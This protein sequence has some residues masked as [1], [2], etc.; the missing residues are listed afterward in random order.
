MGIWDKIQDAAG[1]VKDAAGDAV[2]FLTGGD[3]APEQQVVGVRPEFQGNAFKA[4][5]PSFKMRENEFEKPLWMQ[6]ADPQSP[7]SSWDNDFLGRV[8]KQ[9]DEL[10][11]KGELGTQFDRNDATGVVTW[12]HV[13]KGGKDLKF[14][15][16]LDKGKLIGNLYE[17]KDG[18]EADADLMMSQFLLEPEELAQIGEDRDPTSRMRDVINQRRENN[19]IEIPQALNAAEQQGL[20]DKTQAKIQGAFGGAGDDALAAGIGGIGGAIITGGVATAASGIGFLP[21][22]AITGIG[23]GVSGLAAWLNRDDISEQTASALEISRKAYED[24]EGNILGDTA[25]ASKQWAG[26]AGK[27]LSP[28]S[29]LLRGAVD[30]DRGNGV[31]ALQ[32]EDRPAWA[33]PLDIAATIADMGFTFGSKAGITAY[34]AQMGV[35]SAGGLT[36]LTLGGGQRW[37]AQAGEFRNVYQNEKGDFSAAN[38]LGAWAS[39]G[40]D[41][42][43]LAMV[44]GIAQKISGAD[45][46]AIGKEMNGGIVAKVEDR[47]GRRF[48]LDENKKVL[49]SK[50]NW[51][52]VMVPSEGVSFLAAGGAARSAAA[53]GMRPGQAV[54][55]DFYKASVALERAEAPIKA[56]LV[57]AVGE[58]TEEAVQEA[59]D[60]WSFDNQVDLQS[61]AEA[62]AYGAASGLGMGFAANYRTRD[63]DAK[64]LKGLVEEGYL[65][66]H[67]ALPDN[68]DDTYKKMSVQQRN[69]YTSAVM[70]PEQ[71]EAFKQMMGDQIVLNGSSTKSGQGITNLQNQLIQE[72]QDRLTDKAGAPGDQVNRAAGKP[73]STTKQ[74]QPN[75]SV[76]IR[77]GVVSDDALTSGPRGLLHYYIQRKK[78]LPLVLKTI[79]TQL[80]EAKDEQARVAE[81]LDT[82]MADARVD[83]L[84][85][86]LE[87]WK[88]TDT[89]LPDLIKAVENKV[90]VLTNPEINLKE[91]IRE[92]DEL[93]QQLDTYYRAE[94]PALALAASMLR[95]RSPYDNVGSFHVGAPAVS[96]AAVKDNVEMNFETDWASL[97]V[98]TAD[99]DGDRFTSATGV[100]LSADSFM[101]A[102]SGASWLSTERNVDAD[103]NQ[104]DGSS[105]LYKVAAVAPDKS[106]NLTAHYISTGMYLPGVQGLPAKWLKVFTDAVITRYATQYTTSASDALFD[107]LEA[108]L[109]TKLPKDPIKELMSF[110]ATDPVMSPLMVEYAKN[111]RTNEPSV[112]T[113]MFRSYMDSLQVQIN[114]HQASLVPEAER[115][116]A[117]AAAAKGN[118]RWN[119]PD[120]HR[121]IAPQQGAT[122]LNTFF[123]YYGTKDM[124][125]I[126]QV[127]RLSWVGYKERGMAKADTNPLLDIAAREMRVLAQGH[128]QDA[129]NAQLN[130][131]D[132]PARVRAMALDITDGNE[133]MAFNLLSEPFGDTQFEGKD[134]VK[135]RPN[136]TV[137]QALTMSYIQQLRID[138][139]MPISR[140]PELQMKLNMLETAANDARGFD[141]VKRSNGEMLILKDALGAF[142][143]AD[144]MG[145]G[146]TAEWATSGLLITGSIE[147]N[148]RR[149]MRLPRVDVASIKRKMENQRVDPSTQETYDSITKFIL[150]VA[151]SESARNEDRNETA[152]KAA[153]EVRKNVRDAVKAAGLPQT[154]EGVQALLDGQDGQQIL[155]ALV[156]QTKLASFTDSTEGGQSLRDWVLQ[157]FVEESDGKAEVLLWSNRAIDSITLINARKLM[158]Q[159]DKDQFGQKKEDEQEEDDYTRQDDTLAALMQHLNEHSPVGLRE[160]QEAI[161]KASDRK[162]LEE[163]ISQQDYSFNVP[164]LMYENSMAQFDPSLVSGGWGQPA[165]SYGTAMRELLQPSKSFGKRVT[166]QQKFRRINVSTAERLLKHRDSQPDHPEVLALI[167]ELESR[168]TGAIKT[169]HPNDML[170]SMIRAQY[171]AADMHN[172]GKEHEAVV[173][174]GGP[175]VAEA[176]QTNFS[177]PFIDTANQLFDARD[178]QDLQSRP[179]LVFF[180]KNFTNDLGNPVIMPN[181]RDANGDI[182]IWLVLEQIANN[183]ETGLADLLVEAL[184]PKQR[185]FNRLTG[186]S[187]VTTI[188]PR[189]LH[190]LV[191]QRYDASFKSNGPGR[192]TDKALASFGSAVS[193]AIQA[194]DFTNSAA[195]ERAWQAIAMPRIMS[196]RGWSRGRNASELEKVRKQFAL[197]LMQAG[198]LYNKDPEGYEAAVDTVARNMVLGMNIAQNERAWGRGKERA[199]GVAAKSASRKEFERIAQT[200]LKSMR[201]AG[202]LDQVA[203]IQDA[204]A[205]LIAH[206]S[207][208]KRLSPEDLAAVVASA[209]NAGPTP[210]PLINLLESVLQDEPFSFLHFT[211]G[212]GKVISVAQRQAI[213]AYLKAN[214]TI[215]Y[216]VSHDADATEAMAWFE[217]AMSKDTIFELDAVQWPML[218]RIVISHTVQSESVEAWSPTDRLQVFADDTYLDPTYSLLFKKLFDPTGPLVAAARGITAKRPEIITVDTMAETLAELFPV[219]KSIRWDQSIGAQIMATDATYASSASGSA[220]PVQGNSGK[221]IDAIA[222]A[223]YTTVEKIPPADLMQTRMLRR[224]PQG[225]VG[226]DTD[227]LE[228]AVGMVT[229]DGKPINLEIMVNARVA[230]PYQVITSERLELIANQYPDGTI[231][232]VSFFHPL[233]RP[234]GAEWTNSIYFDGLPGYNSSETLELPSLVASLYNQANGIL[235]LGTRF[236][237]DAVKNGMP[238]VSKTY[239]DANGNYD[240]IG[241]PDPTNYL[242]A[243]ARTLAV[244]TNLGYPALG[245][246]WT[247]PALKYVTMRSIVQYADGSVSSIHSY[248]AQ[249]KLDP[250]AMAARGPKMVMMSERTANSFYGETGTQGLRGFLMSNRVTAGSQACSWDKLTTRQAE[251]AANMNTPVLLSQTSAAR[252]AALSSA[253]PIKPG[254]Y[255]DAVKDLVSLTALMETRDRDQASRP[256]FARKEGINFTEMKT[257]QRTVANELARKDGNNTF[258]PSDEVVQMLARSGYNES[259]FSNDFSYHLVVTANGSLNQ[260]I[261]TPSNYKKTFK[262]LKNLTFGDT[263]VIDLEALTDFSTDTLVDIVRMLT[264][265]KVTISLRGVGANEQ[266]RAVADYLRT[267]YDYSTMLEQPDTFAPRESVNEYQLETAYESRLEQQGFSSAYSKVV[268]MVPVGIIA[269]E[270]GAAA[271]SQAY[272]LDEGERR[273]VSNVQIKQYSSVKATPLHEADLD[274]VSKMLLSMK[275][276]LLAAPVDG[277]IAGLSHEQAVQDLMD[278]AAAGNKMLLLKTEGQNL[279]KGMFDV[280][281]VPSPLGSTMK[282]Y[283]H[284]HGS[285]W[286]QEDKLDRF[287]ISADPFMLG[288]TDTEPNQTTVEGLVVGDTTTGPSDLSLEVESSQKW[289]GIKRIPLLGG[290][291]GMYA[292]LPKPLDWV[293]GEIAGMFKPQELFNT[294]DGMKKLNMLDMV[295]TFSQ[296]AEAFGFD[297]MPIF[298]K[299][300]YGVDYDGSSEH[301]R[302]MDDLRNMLIR[303]PKD[304]TMTP[305]RA[306]MM[307][308]LLAGGINGQHS[309]LLGMVDPELLKGAS[310]DLMAGGETVEIGALLAAI[311][312]LSVPGHSLADIEYAGG[313]TEADSRRADRG[314]LY[315]P[316]SF[317]SYYDHSAAARKTVQDIYRKKLGP[318]WDMNPD[319][320]LRKWF[321]YDSSGVPTRFQDFGFGYVVRSITGEA[322]GESY[323]PTTKT[324]A[325]THNMRLAEQFGDILYAASYSSNSFEQFVQDATTRNAIQTLRQP[326]DRKRKNR[327]HYRMGPFQRT[328]RGNVRRM[329]TYYFHDIDLSDQGEITE[330]DQEQL[331]KDIREI[332]MTLFRDSSGRSDIHVHTMLRLALGRPVM[333]SQDEAEASRIKLSTLKLGLTAMQANIKGG[334]SP[335]R[336]GAVSLLPLEIRNAIIT[337]NFGKKGA[338]APRIYDENNRISDDRAKTPDQYT[339]AFF[340]HSL[341]DPTA[342]SIPTFKQIMDAVFHQYQ[343]QSADI[344]ALPVSLDMMRDLNL[345]RQDALSEDEFEQAFKN[346]V[347][348]AKFSQDNPDLVKDSLFLTTETLMTPT[349]LHEVAGT[350]TMA[351][352][353]GLAD[354][355]MLDFD[356]PSAELLEYVQKRYES[357]ARGKEIPFVTKASNRALR[358]TNSTQTDNHS[359]SHRIFRNFLALH[360]GKALFNPAL[361][362]GALVDAAMRLAIG[363]A[364]RLLTGESTGFIGQR[365]ANVVEKQGSVGVL[366]RGL[367]WRVMF[368]AKQAQ[369]F[370]RILNSTA[371]TGAMNDVI[372]EQLTSYSAELS[373]NGILRPIAALNRAANS[374]Q[375]FGHGTKSKAMRRTYLQTAIADLVLRQGQSLDNVLAGIAQDGAWIDRNFKTSSRAGVQAMNDIRGTQD[376]VVSSAIT[377]LINPATHSGNAGINGVAQMTLAM[378]LMFQRYAANLFLTL[379]GARAIDM[380]AAHALQGRTKPGFWQEISSKAKSQ[381]VEQD[382]T[383]NMDD[384]I[385]GL[386]ALDAVIN[387]GI[388]HSFLFTGGLVIGG[389]GLSGED[390]EEKRRRRAAAAQG[391]VWLSDPRDIENDYRNAHAL[392]LD[393]IPGLNMLFSNDAGRAIA[394]PHWI[395]KPLISPLLG[396]ER[397]FDTGDIRQLKWGFEDAI[398]SLPLLN[399][400]TFNKALTMSEELSF[401]AQD[402]AAQG[403]LGASD[404]AGFLTHLVSYYESALFESSFLNALYTGYDDYDRDP[405]VM[406]LRD[407]DGDLQRDAEGNVRANS[408]QNLTSDG[409][410]GRGKALQTYV[411][412]EG[413]VKEG[414]FTE[415]DSTT[416]SRVL[417]ESRL[418]YALVSSLFTGLAGKGMNT[419]YNMAVKTREVDKPTLKDDEQMAVVLG[420]YVAQAN[421][422]LTAGKNQT[423]EQAIA[424]S[425][426]DNT[427]NEVLSDEGAMAIFRGLAG[428]SVTASDAA[429]QGVYIDFDSRV[430]IQ[431]KWL[432]ELVNEGMKL[433][434]SQSQAKFRANKVWYGEGELPGISEILFNKDIPYSK[435]QEF[436]QLN[437]TYIKGPD[438]NIWATGFARSK[439]LGAMG[440]APL[441]GLQTSNDTGTDMDGRMNVAGFGINNT[442]MRSLRP[443]NDSLDIPT[444]VEIGDTV[445]KAIE[446]LNLNDYGGGFGRRGFGGG[447]GGGGYAQRPVNNNTY[448][449]RWTNQNFNPISL[450]VPYANDVYSLRTDDVRTDLST[451]RRERISSERGRLSPWQ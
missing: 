363:D 231:V 347:S 120:Q 184:L 147:Q 377:A 267:L 45:Q 359:N 204:L 342:N 146:D 373:K 258:M 179:E 295:G 112:L 358:D 166:K 52:Q 444:D 387:M 155:A 211:Y 162:S 46:R 229:I 275:K 435:T 416:K 299:G 298:F 409:I 153:M 403:N 80:A 118:P 251:I 339:R 424:L 329:L 165:K 443:V 47:A 63:N 87:L 95:L 412:D 35:H 266:T 21:G 64:E 113:G 450:R 343:E 449:A 139:A 27:G 448:P 186:Q 58:G 401:A 355:K 380:L 114:Q 289:I 213:M 235:Q 11:D 255:S 273:V 111:N 174:Y 215:K 338:W 108:R 44:R 368:T 17:D 106:V 436:Q 407:S 316:T 175:Q 137:A 70:S 239:V 168:L 203:A 261:V 286:I 62:Y 218:S 144:L 349:I 372:Y 207:G 22:L 274:K 439:F 191:S 224:G 288:R 201:E 85:K 198:F 357:Y 418:S 200:M 138:A 115:K 411:D 32:E 253:E 123:Q 188:G 302:K 426:L 423:A 24:G 182:D 271:E 124:L 117:Q 325:S 65:G 279:R 310:V 374:I 54:A 223:S 245:K 219:D 177:D 284:R 410:D 420:A 96:L 100:A 178:I 53:K 42:A 321:N 351:Q 190:E 210:A 283:L 308:R 365:M 268:A 381:N 161:G 19:N 185:S 280:Y 326:A 10:V 419:R 300:F 49:E 328:Y 3:E 122:L 272:M 143:L 158:K 332:A 129:S 88:E 50:V 172:K 77:D 163:W 75:G 341:E 388:T 30:S 305:N 243:L 104:L 110:F 371:L 451:I 160:L 366:A 81:G 428:G 91:R 99:F 55:D 399:M 119:A 287:A 180:T 20:V 345:L 221:I 324:S 193:A 217:E 375:D 304:S 265:S 33:K 209:R 438:G 364:R 382:P 397:F 360:A 135:A 296:A 74:R 386:D 59:L 383:I 290:D 333:S 252:R 417:A 390:E 405:Y 370:K 69:S 385:G 313:F 205:K 34:T 232:E 8:F 427:G 281:V 331:K 141:K 311:S 142:N 244:T 132:I 270:F 319:Y 293:R 227:V 257:Q 60:A 72:E 57:N 18:T 130:E 102:R 109:L 51:S 195:F 167:D 425:F 340:D 26:V 297:N 250:Q 125:R 306:A 78:N 330:G 398:T 126:G 346:P 413:N 154:I 361:G 285:K 315:M 256:Q 327:T 400:V 237:L 367:G 446:N 150:E 157:F 84:Q 94:N 28:F 61:L 354:P 202:R 76:R 408:D 197:A 128:I 312:Y 404:S 260:G 433:G 2:D 222:M 5:N 447:G 121:K 149:L 15:D 422:A 71:T 379:T 309:A 208:S 278:R 93:N 92:L 196:S 395:L 171:V 301:V 39:T 414:Y 396:M 7:Y 176:I 127:I 206:E 242:M 181:F 393:N 262:A 56:A 151:N 14:G 6:G 89:Y 317:T 445:T 248:M 282:L 303:V 415:S 394:S 169:I 12:D 323:D 362:I 90:A 247:R 68:W 23:A 67:G 240:L 216:Q 189:T 1:D 16:I 294:A 307:S 246:E 431:D 134:R 314:S 66:T 164:V 220:A 291:K 391:A 234:A 48:Y 369:E 292:A 40:I 356:A 29:N 31:G 376:T 318:G 145:V 334:Y 402:S 192:Y 406:P 389:L 421:E 86:M 152:S 148:I 437:T 230:P 441:Q 194:Q 277:E 37:D 43:Q 226:A 101:R 156:S 432:D 434:L 238:S 378:P 73:I 249:Q 187:S 41:V 79:E 173:A 103:G 140:N 9:Q 107:K 82:S 133:A 136:V 131:F 259:E 236:V 4:V 264:L 353:L 429:L 337:A 384:V 335:L 159:R 276:E 241:D 263:A 352:Q 36:E 228:G 254:A 233:D 320:T 212:E 442:G 440:I 348:F 322:V 269:P 199:Y 116:G 13:T 25:S 225:L 38:A 214:P 430:K 344:Q 336:G 183:A 170:D 83:Q 350:A 105:T 98:T 392:F 97:D